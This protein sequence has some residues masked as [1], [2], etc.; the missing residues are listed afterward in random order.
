MDYAERIEFLANQ[1]F[2]D[3]VKD[4]NV[5]SDAAFRTFWMLIQEGRLGP[6]EV[7]MTA[8]TVGVITAALDPDLAYR[9]KTLEGYLRDRV[10]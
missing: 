1:E 6:R 9:A 2:P 10:G 3:T 4:L 5:R 8:W 7:F